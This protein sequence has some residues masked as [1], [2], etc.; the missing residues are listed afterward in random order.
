MWTSLSIGVVLVSVC[1]L[2]YSFLMSVSVVKIKKICQL[3]WTLR[4][5]FLIEKFLLCFCQCMTLISK[6]HSVNHVACLFVTKITKALQIRICTHEV[7]TNQHN[8]KATTEQ[9]EW[10]TSLILYQM[11]SILKCPQNNV[12]ESF[13]KKICV[14]SVLIVVN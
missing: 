7:H 2:I 14:F 13:L 10:K 12:V 6:T 8:F 3:G 1:C 11:K 9:K 4:I 5:S